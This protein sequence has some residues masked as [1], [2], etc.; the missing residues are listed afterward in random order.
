MQASPKLSPI[1]PLLSYF[2]FLICETDL[3]E[4]IRHFPSLVQR[5]TSLVMMLLLSCSKI[6]LSG[7][8]RHPLYSRDKFLLLCTH[9][10]SFIAVPLLRRVIVHPFLAVLSTPQ[11]VCPCY[12][13]QDGILIIALRPSIVLYP[14]LIL[15][16]RQRLFYMGPLNGICKHES[17][18]LLCSSRYYCPFP[19]FSSD[20]MDRVSS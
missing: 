2:G 4:S 15:Q 7:W 16:H 18:T 11:A 17:L 6:S 13:L 5:Q 3:V 1:R 14:L 12:L 10:G 9:F 19:K 20:T 8:R